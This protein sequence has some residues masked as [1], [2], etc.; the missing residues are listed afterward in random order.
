MNKVIKN[1]KSFVNE[2]EE[3]NKID[4]NQ[5]GPERKISKEEYEKLKGRKEN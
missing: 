1:Y 2:A 3:S 4:V 5:P